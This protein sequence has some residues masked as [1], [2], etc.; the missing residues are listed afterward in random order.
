[1]LI[2]SI[3]SFNNHYLE[4]YLKNVYI[5][6]YH[7]VLNIITCLDNEINVNYLIYNLLF[8]LNSILLAYFQLNYINIVNYLFI[9]QHLY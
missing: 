4:N 5:F 9:N 8:L 6:S 3:I 2:I 1:M 7:S